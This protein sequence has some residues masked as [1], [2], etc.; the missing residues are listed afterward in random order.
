MRQATIS[1]A[2]GGHKTTEQIRASLLQRIRGY[3]AKQTIAQ[4]LVSA[5]VMSAS[6]GY[7]AST[8]EWTSR[9]IDRSGEGEFVALRE[10]DDEEESGKD[11]DD[12]EE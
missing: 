4:M 10:G 5:L 3:L 2:H 7:M 8:R 9:R 6:S 12:G 1:D 11:R